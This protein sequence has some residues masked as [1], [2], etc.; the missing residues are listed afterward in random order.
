MTF[1]LSFKRIVHICEETVSTFILIIQLHIPMLGL[2]ERKVVK[3]VPGL[4]LCQEQAKDPELTS[5]G[6]VKIKFVIVTVIEV[7]VVMVQNADFHIKNLRPLL[8][9]IAAIMT[10]IIMLM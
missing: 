10:Q 9:K 4:D 1:A 3:E 8:Q 2:L 7:S 6:T 5:T